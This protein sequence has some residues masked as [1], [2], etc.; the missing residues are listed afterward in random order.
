MSSTCLI[1]GASRGIGLELAT[2]YA[3]DGWTVHA[4]TRTVDQPGPLGEIPGDVTLHQMDVRSNADLE[5]LLVSLDGMPI[6]V[7][8][9]GAGVYRNTPREV[10]MAVNAESPIRVADAVLENV[11]ASDQ[12]KIALITS[13]LGARRGR[14]GS[15]GDYGDSKAALNDA[16]RLRAPGWAE[17]GIRA[18]VIHPGWVSTDMG[19]SSAPVSVSESAAGIRRLM[20][21][22]TTQMHGGF[23]TWDGREHEW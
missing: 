8:I 4:T 7:L 18:I 13:Q 17:R 22:L 1:V 16:F 21:G 9:H 10:I 2:Q 12:R 14:T 6:D 3:V 11:A 5:A 20:G 19:G 23:W 15:L